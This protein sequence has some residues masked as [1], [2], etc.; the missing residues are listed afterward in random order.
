MAT[1]GQPFDKPFDVIGTVEEIAESPHLAAT[2]TLCDGDRDR[3]L[4]DIQSHK[5]DIVHW[6]RPPRLRLG[7][8]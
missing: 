7:A 2:S 4:M 5:N 1:P 3:R 6:A 8:G